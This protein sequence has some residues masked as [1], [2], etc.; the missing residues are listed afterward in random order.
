MVFTDIST[1]E[2]LVKYRVRLEL[3][4]QQMIVH[5]LIQLPMP[6]FVV[7]KEGWGTGWVSGNVVRFNT[8]AAMYP[9][10]V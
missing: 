10:G 6:Y 7:K 9:S 1:L 3:A 2:S 5:R 4:Q 8:I